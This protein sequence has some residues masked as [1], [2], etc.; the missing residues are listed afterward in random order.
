MS[1]IDG[2]INDLIPM[3]Y[4][5]LRI[6]LGNGARSGPLDKFA[7]IHKTGRSHQNAETRLRKAHRTG[8]TIIATCEPWTTEVLQLRFGIRV[9]FHETDSHH[10]ENGAV[11]K[12][13]DGGIIKAGI[14]VG[15]PTTGSYPNTDGT[16][17]EEAAFAPC[18]IVAESPK[19]IRFS[20]I[21]TWNGGQ[22][23][24]TFHAHPK[25]VLSECP[26]EVW[27]EYVRRFGT[28]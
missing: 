2:I 13:K 18:L 19:P 3:P 5:G 12:N 10:E 14:V 1:N 4:Q 26:I 7:I 16:A 6:K 27:N 24:G 15:E 28:L 8:N 11:V 22:F 9:F 21:Y 17:M 20:E 25:G 23:E